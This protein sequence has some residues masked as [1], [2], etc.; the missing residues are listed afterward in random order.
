[1]PTRF[2][3][4]YVAISRI[5]LFTNGNHIVF[6][7]DA[8][9]QWYAPMIA[10]AHNRNMLAIRE[11]RENTNARLG[12]PNKKLMPLL[13]FLVRAC[14]V[15]C[16]RPCILV[17]VTQK[18]GPFVCAANYLFASICLPHIWMLHRPPTICK[19]TRN[20]GSLRWLHKF[21]LAP[22]HAQRG[23]WFSNFSNNLL[24][25]HALEMWDVRWAFGPPLTSNAAMQ[26]LHFSCSYGVCVCVPF[27]RSRYA[28]MHIL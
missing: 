5:N 3:F 25:V 7:R 13:F 27:L 1:M 10:P 28:Q 22:R 4:R 23:D 21:E 18:R 6:L 26:Q 24:F 8:F 17:T 2:R 14:C 11:V 20:V 19:P 12:Q 15:R 16:V 9:S